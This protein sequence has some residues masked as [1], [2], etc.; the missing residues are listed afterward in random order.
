MQLGI[1]EEEAKVLVVVEAHAVIYP[2]ALRV[3]DVITRDTRSI[4]T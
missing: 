2:W 4:F 1:K 3:D